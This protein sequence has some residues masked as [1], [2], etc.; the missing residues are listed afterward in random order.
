[1]APDWDFSNPINRTKR[2]QRRWFVLYDD[3][4]LTYSVDD[5]PETIPQ[6]CIDMN[7]VME[8]ARADEV[9]GNPFSVAITATDRVHFVKGTCK[10]E[11][12]W[13]LEVLQIFPTKSIKTGRAKRNATFPGGISTTY[14]AQYTGTKLD[15]PPVRDEV[16]DSVT[17]DK[18]VT[19][20]EAASVANESIMNKTAPLLIPARKEPLAKRE[21]TP[22]ENKCEAGANNARYKKIK[23]KTGDGTR[24]YRSLRSNTCENLSVIPTS[25]NATSRRS[26]LSKLSNPSPLVTNFNTNNIPPPQLASPNA[27]VPK[28]IS[29]AT[30]THF[31]SEVSTTS[32]RYNPSNDSPT[33]KSSSNKHEQNPAPP[34]QQ[35]P[36]IQ[37]ED[38]VDSESSGSAVTPNSDS[39]NSPTETLPVRG[40]PDGCGLDSSPQPSP[41]PSPVNSTPDTS[42]TN[43]TQGR[44]KI[45]T[46]SALELLNLK[47]G[48]LM[49]QQSPSKEW[50]KHWFV[51][52]GSA[53]MY[54]RDP[55]AE[56]NGLLDG[57]IDL[58][59]VSK[60]EERDVARNYGFIVSTLDERQYVLSAVTHGIRNNW[61][62]A[63]KSAANLKNIPEKDVSSK[64]LLQVDEPSR[65]KER[66][67]DS[68]RS[69]SPQKSRSPS[70]NVNVSDEKSSMP[71]ISPPLTRTPTSRLKKEKSKSSRGGVGVTNG[72]L[73]GVSLS[74]SGLPSVNNDTSEAH[75]EVADD[76]HV[77]DY[78]ML[79]ER[80][81]STSKQTKEKNTTSMTSGV[82]CDSLP[83]LTTLDKEI[84]A[85][86]SQIDNSKAELQLLHNDFTESPTQDITRQSTKKMTFNEFNNSDPSMSD[87][88]MS[89]FKSSILETKD[90]L[91]K[92][93]SEIKNLRKR[94]DHTNSDMDTTL[95]NLNNEQV[96]NA[97]KEKRIQDLEQS[98]TL[99]TIK[100]GNAEK[101]LREQSK[102]ITSLNQRVQEFSDLSSQYK[103]QV[104]ENKSLRHKLDK[105]ERM[106]NGPNWKIL[107]ESLQEQHVKERGIWENK[108]REMENEMQNISDTN[109]EAEQ[110]THIIADLSHQLQ[111][112]EQRINQLLCRT[113]SLEKE[114]T[115]LVDGYDDEIQR[116]KETIKELEEYI[117]KTDSDKNI[118][119]NT[120]D[121][122]IMRLRQ[123]LSNKSEF[124]SHIKELQ[125]NLTK[126]ETE[127]D[128]LK[129]ALSQ[130]NS[131]KKQSADHE[132]QNPMDIDE[133]KVKK[134]AS[135]QRIDSM[136]ELRLPIEDQEYLTTLEQEELIVCYSDLMKLYTRMK[137]ETQNLKSKVKS[138][139]NNADDM[140]L[141]NIR[142][143]G[144]LSS[145]EEQYA[146]QLKVMTANINDL[147]AKYLA[148]EKQVRSL[149]VKCAEGK[150]RRRSSTGIR[151]DEFLVNKEAEHVLD[152]IEVNLLNTEG[153]VKGKEPITREGRKKSYEISTKA[154]RARRRSSES[155]ELSFV[156]RLKK[157]EKT[158]IDLNRKLSYQGENTTVH[159]EQLRKQIAGV[160]AKCKSNFNNCDMNDPSTVSEQIEEFLNTIEALLANSEVPVISIEELGFPKSDEISSHLDIV[161]TFLFKCVENI[162]ELRKDSEKI[163]LSASKMVTLYDVSGNVSSAVDL[164][165]ALQAQD[166]TLQAYLL[167]DLQQQV[168]LIEKKI[169]SYGRE[170]TIQD[171]D[172][173][174]KGTLLKILERK[175]FVPIPAYTSRKIALLANVGLSHDNLDKMFRNLQSEAQRV[176]TQISGLTQEIINILADGLVLKI[177]EKK[178]IV[179]NVKSEVLNLIEENERLQEFQT[180]L[181]NIFLIC[182]TN[183]SG[184]EPE[185]ATLMLNREE[186]LQSQAEVSRILIDQEV[187]DLMN[188]VENRIECTRKDAKGDT[189]KELVDIDNVNDCI[190]RVANMMSQK[191]ITEAQITIINTI[192][193]CNGAEKGHNEIDV[194]M[195]D[196]PADIYV[197]N[198]ENMNNECN[199]FMLVLNNYRQNNGQSLSLPIP[200]ISSGSNNK[201]QLETNLMSIRRENENKKARLSAAL[202]ERQINSS[203]EEKIEKL[204]SWCEKSM[205]NMEKSY[206]NLLHD[207]QT[208]HGKEKD[209]LRSEKEQ[210]LAEETQATL[211]ALDAMRKAHESE[212]QKEVE[213]FKKGFLQ[214][215]QAKACI[216]AIQSEYQKDRAE[217]QREILSTVS[218]GSDGKQP[219]ISDYLGET[220]SGLDVR[221]R[222]HS[223]AS[224]LGRS[225]SCPRLYSTLSLSTAPTISSTEEGEEEGENAPLRSPLT[226]MVANRKRVFENEY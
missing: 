148:A 50:Q 61:I 178:A 153:L 130:A 86:Q 196:G 90:I 56:N 209:N 191:C 63:L 115:A 84:N 19:T 146:D 29:P 221:G 226:G 79:P 89:K 174:T 127:V 45:P 161:M 106:N 198:P 128:C 158:I 184:K 220:E 129:I 47:K 81:I 91:K 107:Y 73:K 223:R 110:K 137:N 25:D 75:V 206:E 102:E 67:S 9:T 144:S 38:D 205:T 222:E 172:N 203:E 170:Q 93:T 159:L 97:E 69:P 98:N 100:S 111:D 55:S 139:Q 160:I 59:L 37:I 121:S 143:K 95:K 24:A 15:T 60:V 16:E 165:K 152:D 207:M 68:L 116:L 20:N 74:L 39:S 168:A 132:K 66:N 83:L 31:T 87:E 147:T 200:K 80:D 54:F 62:N 167:L 114:K 103:A 51:L 22:D 181:I 64:Q 82:P 195:V 8:V 96:K 204:R 214:D 149:K 210:A 145:V 101:S 176:F 224:K 179:D 141:V 112:S 108:L 126:S 117:D 11:S 189:T 150:S 208:Q 173:L 49:K 163:D 211:A 197:F 166:T 199:E 157:T 53:L 40:V 134:S 218:R 194:D 125:D 72:G 76:D 71:Q 3:G 36:V 46:P 164:S 124:E 7:K 193:G 131:G 156:D 190:I 18:G 34:I 185:K 136:A 213:K 21:A 225:P 212:V 88:A 78:N 138:S 99:L 142:L 94:L 109:N 33:Q 217:M 32:V 2:W 151:P 104:L 154:S 183:D 171:Y 10:E 180:S 202:E 182:S 122:E 4:E 48:W 186:A 52:Q 133:S 6:A 201:N 105:M 35:Q 215:F 12:T 28:L 120:K 92:Q 192:L 175:Q 216:G 58:G 113:D 26:R 123:E 5:H 17:Q 119:N 42:S 135:L 177:T 85:L 77:D 14:V 155:S 23:T 43:S 118:E 140:E 30:P 13:W 187:Q 41:S 188:A 27:S 70:L 57:I 65:S 169:F 1:M 162:Y 219:G 44:A